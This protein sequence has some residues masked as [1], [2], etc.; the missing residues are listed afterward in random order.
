MALNISNEQQHG[1]PAKMTDNTLPPELERRILEL[2][3]SENQGSGFTGVD[4]LLLALTGV[5]GP[6]L[7]LIWGWN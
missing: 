2:E 1:R 7:L 4:W 3:K 6:V 5:I